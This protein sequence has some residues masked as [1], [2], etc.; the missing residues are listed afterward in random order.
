MVS[1]EGTLIRNG[2]SIARVDV[3]CE[4]NGSDI[5]GVMTLPVENVLVGGEYE[6]RLGDASLSALIA[7]TNEAPPT[8]RISPTKKA[9]FSGRLI[10]HYA[11]N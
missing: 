11:R 8:T 2:K 4:L 7:I 10:L 1:T 6:L 5:H 3:L 9:A